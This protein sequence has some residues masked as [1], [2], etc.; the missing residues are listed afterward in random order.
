MI[1]ILCLK[2]DLKI[3]FSLAELIFKHD[4]YLKIMKN[5]LRIL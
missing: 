5:Q 4:F 2:S 1:M 3:D